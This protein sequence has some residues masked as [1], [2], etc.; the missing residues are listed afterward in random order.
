MSFRVG[1]YA[2][3]IQYSTLFWVTFDLSL[4]SGDPLFFFGYLNFQHHIH[5]SKVPSDQNYHG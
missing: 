5:I 1:S 2:I 3:V 4:T